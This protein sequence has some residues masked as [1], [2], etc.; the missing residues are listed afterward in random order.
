MSP[1]TSGDLKLPPQGHWRAGLSLGGPCTDW[2]GPL[3]SKVPQ[4]QHTSGACEI[5]QHLN[6]A[7]ELPGQD[8]A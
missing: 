3:T 7:P 4:S 1:F 6:S 2:M 8:N 5:K